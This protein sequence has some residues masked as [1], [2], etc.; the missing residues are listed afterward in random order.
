AVAIDVCNRE[1]VSMVV[2]RRLVRLAGIVH[3]LVFERD[4]AL[5]EPVCE[6]EA[7]KCGD[8]LDAL[9][10]SL[11]KPI[12]PPRVLEICRNGL[13]RRVACGRPRDDSQWP[14]VTR[15]KENR[16][17]EQKQQRRESAY[18]RQS[19]HPDWLFHLVASA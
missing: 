2:M 1:P 10:L 14:E 3:D 8:R 18:V 15:E 6:L 5:F 4:A 16:G 12:H 9:E 17:A 11:P 7:V 13:D 19:N